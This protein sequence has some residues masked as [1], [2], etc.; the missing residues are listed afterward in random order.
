MGKATAEDIADAIMRDGRKGI[1]RA[2]VV[3]GVLKTLA[4]LRYARRSVAKRQRPAKPL[5]AKAKPGTVILTRKAQ[6][7]VKV[8]TLTVLTAWK[9]Q[10]VALGLVTKAQ[11]LSEAERDQ[12]KG[13]GYFANVRFYEALAQ[14]MA[15]SQTVQQVWN[16][17]E[18]ETLKASIWPQDQA[19]SVTCEQASV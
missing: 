8:R 19:G 13:E 11:L 7:Q 5:P 15:A 3:L 9:I 14:R 6:E 16:V 1:V 4:E 18:V 17:E 2:F 12:R 10:G